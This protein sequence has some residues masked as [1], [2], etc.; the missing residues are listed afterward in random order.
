MEIGYENGCEQLFYVWVPNDLLFLKYCI[1]AV[2]SL[3][4]ANFYY[5]KF[6]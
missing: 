1:L 3:L 2:Y 4:I 6:N 5:L